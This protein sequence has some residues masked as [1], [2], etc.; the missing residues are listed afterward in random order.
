[1]NK[2]NNYSFISNSFCD[3]D[4]SEDNFSQKLIFNNYITQGSIPFLNTID[5]NE[6]N[7]LHIMDKEEKIGKNLQVFLKKLIPDTIDK[8]KD[9]KDILKINQ[10]YCKQY[11]RKIKQDNKVLNPAV[12][13]IL[14]TDF[15]DKF[16]FNKTNLQHV[17]NILVYAINEIK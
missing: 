6:C 2:I 14:A 1:M 10:D 16:I 17:S 12:N 5:F 15:K 13:E 9:T 11:F 3:E 4:N 8:A 7:S